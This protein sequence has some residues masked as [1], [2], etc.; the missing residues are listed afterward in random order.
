MV[1]AISSREKRV[2]SERQNV[3][4]LCYF[5][6]LSKEITSINVDTFLSLKKFSKVRLIIFVVT[7]LSCRPFSLDIFFYFCLM[8]LIQPSLTVKCH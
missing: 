2:C 3:R 8:L 4:Q 1:Q 6:C 7:I 5:R